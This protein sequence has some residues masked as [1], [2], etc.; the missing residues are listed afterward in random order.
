LQTDL[1][2]Y[3]SGQRIAA[4]WVKKPFVDYV[5]E[6]DLGEQ[7]FNNAFFERNDDGFFVTRFSTY[8]TPAGR[9]Y[10]AIW[11]KGVSSAALF[12]GNTF[13]EYQDLYNQFV[14]EQ[15][16]SLDQVVGYTVPAPFPLPHSVRF[17]GL[18][19]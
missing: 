3:A 2:V 17:A 10:A 4:S 12:Y 16:L 19:R 8:M 14:N 13:G 1:F 7:A 9:R 11:Q 18:W 6:T 5:V 15:G